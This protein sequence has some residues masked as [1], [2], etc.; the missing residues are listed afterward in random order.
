MN[1]KQYKIYDS[2]LATILNLVEKY[3]LIWYNG[4]I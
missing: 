2:K 4:Y 3:V 1:K